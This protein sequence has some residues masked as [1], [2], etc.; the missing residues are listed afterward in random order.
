LAM[1]MADVH[2]NKSGVICLEGAY[3]GI[4]R[5]TMDISPYKWNEKYKPSPHVTISKSPCTYRGALAG[6]TN[7]KDYAKYIETIV[8]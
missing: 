2:T 3:H 5:A 1:Q 6:H 8:K 4:T 7:S